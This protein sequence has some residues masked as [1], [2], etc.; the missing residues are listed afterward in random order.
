MKSALIALVA[1]FLCTSMFGQ[2]KDEINY[3][4]PF[5][6]DSSEIFLIPR[7]IDNENQAAYGKGKGY[8]PWGNYHDIYF[9]NTNTNT[10]RKLFD[11]TLAIIHTFTERNYYNKPV[12]EYPLNIL[13]KHIVYL[14]RTDNFNNDNGLDSDDPVY[15]Y[16]SA[17]NGENLRVITPKG[18]HILSWTASKDRKILMVK[19]MKDSNGN[20][21]F[22][23][24]DDE[25]YYRIDLD[26]N[27][28]N[29]KCYPVL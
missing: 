17:R 21:K 7:L 4:D 19:A 1:I 12:N 8:L 28:S 24:G 27:I 10:T 14:V 13:P 6:I 20:K 3:S 29:I 16:I 26:E 23:V 2:K 15:L 11:T 18:V 5:Q 22:G 25:I 9:Y